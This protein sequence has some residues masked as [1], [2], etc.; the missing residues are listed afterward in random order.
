VVAGASVGTIARR[1]GDRQA[2]DNLSDQDLLREVMNTV[3]KAG[4]L[5]ETVRYAASPTS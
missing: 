2:A 1:T 4:Q 3:G 5:G